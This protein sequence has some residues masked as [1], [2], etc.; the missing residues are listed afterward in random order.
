MDPCTCLASTYLVPVVWHPTPSPKF[1]KT[2]LMLH[3]P[4]RKSHAFSIFSI[5]YGFERLMT[6]IKQLNLG[7]NFHYE[8]TMNT[9]FIAFK[10]MREAPVVPVHAYPENMSKEEN[11]LKILAIRASG[12]GS[13]QETDARTD[14]NLGFDYNWRYTSPITGVSTK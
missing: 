14:L 13:K 3:K 7:C 5:A 9:F 8:Q 2:M 4:W 11:M 6:K 1:A 12:G 10:V